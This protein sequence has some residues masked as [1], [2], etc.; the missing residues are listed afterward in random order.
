MS[1]DSTRK[2]EPTARQLVE[3]QANDDGL[4]FVATTITEAYLQQALR[5]L[6]EAVE[7]SSSPEREEPKKPNPKDYKHGKNDQNYI[8][9][10]NKYIWAM[11]MRRSISEYD[12]PV[13][14]ISGAN[15]N[16]DNLMN[17]KSVEVIDLQKA[18][19]LGTDR[20]K[21]L[22]GVETKE[23]GQA[24]LWKELDTALGLDK[25]SRDQ[26][27]IAKQRFHLTKKQ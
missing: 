22:R 26:I 5:K 27:P 16:T 13:N 1:I 17:D 15:S 8:K 19:K 20:K 18:P 21:E 3:Q 25:I 14:D 11:A 12:D 7:G 24:E 23:D 10:N 4:W 9:D 6:H 2:E